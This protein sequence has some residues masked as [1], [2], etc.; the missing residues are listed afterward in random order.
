M[1]G[2]TAGGEAVIHKLYWESPV[3]ISTIAVKNYIL[4][5]LDRGT[6]LYIVFSPPFWMAMDGYWLIC[7]HL[8]D[9]VSLHGTTVSALHSQHS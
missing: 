6:K 8:R 4:M 7:L 3:I 2:L 5:T 1:A 9:L